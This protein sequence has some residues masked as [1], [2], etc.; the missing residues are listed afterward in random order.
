MDRDQE[1]HGPSNTA[2][3][4]IFR[5]S[6]DTTRVEIQTQMAHM[7]LTTNMAVYDMF[8]QLQRNLCL[9]DH[10]TLSNK[11]QAI[12]GR[13]SP[14]SLMDIY[15]PGYASYITGE[16]TYVAKCVPVEVSKEDF[17]NCTQEIPARYNTR[18][19]F[20][21]PITRVLQT[22]PTI[23]PCSDVMPIRWQLEE[24]WFCATPETRKCAPPLTLI[25]ITT[26]ALELDFTSGMGRG[27]YTE[28]QLKAHRRFDSAR[29]VRTPVVA[30]V[31]NRAAS[32]GD[33]I[34]GK[35]GDILGYQD[36]EFIQHIMEKQL[37]PFLYNMGIGFYY[38]ILAM[39]VYMILR[40]LFDFALRTYAIYR[41]RGCGIWILGAVTDI[42]F[43]LVMLPGKM[44]KLVYYDLMKPIQSIGRGYA[45]PPEQIIEETNGEQTTQNTREEISTALTND[46]HT[47]TPTTR[48]VDTN[49]APTTVQCLNAD[50][51]LLENRDHTSTGRKNSAA[52]ST[53]DP[54]TGTNR[55]FTNWTHIR[56]ML[57]RQNTPHPHSHLR[58]H[59][60]IYTEELRTGEHPLRRRSSSMEALYGDQENNKE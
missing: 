32:S 6:T 28:E 43:T 19:M 23:V 60:R 9:I 5:V 44:I 11:L 33:P 30:M 38:T 4:D 29:L 13:S 35:M 53:G 15:G 42:T 37:N 1:E 57:K 3:E 47:S 51:P 39:F 16:V 52:E 49:L 58:D 10:K 31:A 46:D 7:H 41:L 2:N 34:T 12:A 59:V 55:R 27:I 18:L 50:T 22:R 21:N 54:G 40:H 26:S 45:A 14:Y 24:G 17:P 8:Q 25:P 20:V 56:N 36:M 48:Q